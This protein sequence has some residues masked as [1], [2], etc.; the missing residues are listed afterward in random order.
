MIKEYLIIAHLQMEIRILAI[1]AGII[2]LVI[3]IKKTMHHHIF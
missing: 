3:D 1:F 2:T